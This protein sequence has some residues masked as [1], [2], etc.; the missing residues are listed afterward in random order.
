MTDRLSIR[1][2]SFALAA[3]ITIAVFMG[4]DT[5]ALQQAAS[6]AQLA[7]VSVATIAQS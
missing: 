1:L 3:L 7:R 4:I 2:T 5:M 6:S